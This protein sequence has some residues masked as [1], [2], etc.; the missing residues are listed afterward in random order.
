MKKKLIVGLD[1][2]GVV[3][4]NPFRI[5]RAPI[6]Y[7]K[8]NFL[9]VKKLKFIYPRYRW[10]QAVWTLLHESSVYPGNGIELLRE[11]TAAG[12]IETHLITA[13]YHFLDGHLYRWLDKYKMRKLFKTVNL[14]KDDQQPHLFKEMLI[15]KIKPDIFVEDN[16]DIVR[17]LHTVQEQKG[18]KHTKIYWIYNLFDRS[19]PYP[20]KFPYLGKALEEIRRQI[21]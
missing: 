6:S 7:V 5:I 16:L 1:F 15:E 14:N 19:V 2:D 18:K 10:Q 17:Y 20:H 12:L 4:Y 3:A 8:R 13:R 21:K 9:G 11:L